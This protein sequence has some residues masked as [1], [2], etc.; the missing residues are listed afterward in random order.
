MFDYC[1]RKPINRDPGNSIGVG[2]LLKNS[3]TNVMKSG[4]Y[5]QFYIQLIF[6]VKY[7]EAIIHPK[8]QDEVYKYMSGTINSMGHKALA[9]NGMPDHIHVLIGLHPT[10]AI[11]DLAKELKRSS[12]NF[13]N[14][15]NWMPGKFQWQTGYGGFSYSRSQIDYVINYIKNQKAHHQ[16]KTFKE[17]YLEFLRDFEVD[18][19]PDFLFDFFK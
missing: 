11:S 19:N 2:L 1:R 16:K 10:M 5:T 9:V 3:K 12:T 15:K 18:Y 14:Q 13:I 17:E 7:R 6:A 4:T 8:F